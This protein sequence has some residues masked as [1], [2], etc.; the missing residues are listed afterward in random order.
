MKNKQRNSNQ[1]LEFS[2][3]IDR[4]QHS[5]FDD[6]LN[7]RVQIDELI[8]RRFFKKITVMF[9]DLKDSTSL[10]EELG[11][12]EARAFI[13]RHNDILIPIIQKRG[14]LIKTLGDG[15]MSYFEKPFNGVEAALEIQ[16]VLD[17]FNQNLI[18]DR[19]ILIRIGIHTGMGIVERNDI[20]GDVVNVASRMESLAQANQIIISEDTFQEI[21]NILNLMIKSKGSSSLKGKKESISVHQLFWSKKEYEQE[22]SD[23]LEK[24]RKKNE[25]N[26][27]DSS[28]ESKYIILSVI[29]RVERIADMLPDKSERE[30]ISLCGQASGSLFFIKEELSKHG[31]SIRNQELQDWGK[32]LEHTDDVYHAVHTL[33]A[34][35]AFLRGLSEKI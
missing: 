10:T 22:I 6:I 27:I 35:A 24:D 28:K 31:I 4:L 25:E 9:T 19:P 33:H 12:L 18:S 5:N 20:F 2:K 32:V 7:I 29:A 16:S 34:A 26:S 11:D 15:T 23:S 14:E 1:E 17:G 13:K 3:I 30:I 21:K 8:K